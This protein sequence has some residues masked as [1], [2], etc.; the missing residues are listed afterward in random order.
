MSIRLA[1]I[2]VFTILIFIFLLS[3]FPA[4]SAAAN[5]VRAPYLQLVTSDSV[6]IVWRTDASDPLDDPTD[7][8]VQFGIVQ[9]NLVQ[10]IT[11]SSVKPQS[12]QNVRDHFVTLTGLDPNTLYYYD[13]GTISGGI[14]GGGTAEHYA[15]TAPVS[16][17]KTAFR[18]WVVG[19]TGVG[20]GNQL[21]VRDAMLNETNANG[22]KQDLFL[23]LGDIAYNDGTDSEFT[24]KHF[25]VYQDIL[26]NTPFYSAY[27]N[28]EA[29]SSNAA[30]QTGPYYEA[31]VLPGNGQAGGVASNTEAYYSFDYANV[32]FVV[33]DSSESSTE[34]GS[35]QISW[36]T[37][38]LAT[39]NQ[40][41]IIAMA[42]HS[43]YTKGT[44][45]SDNG[46]DSD[47]LQVKMRE[48]VLQVLEAGG[49]DLV[50]SGHS[51]AYERSFLIDGVY[52]FGS[53]PNFVT[54]NFVTLQNNG[55]I[56]DS[57]N[58]NP[59]G[60]GEYTKNSDKEG[61]V[62]LVSGTGGQANG[63]FFGC[64]H[65]VM[66]IGE[67][68]LSS[69]LLDVDGYTI[70][71]RNVRSS[72]IISDTFVM[73]KPERAPVI[74]DIKVLNP[75]TIE[76]LFNEVLDS[77]SAEILTNYTID[78]GIGVNGVTL[79]ADQK[80][81]TLTTDTLSFDFQYTVTATGVL[82]LTPSSNAS[83]DSEQFF[84]GQ[85]IFCSYLILGL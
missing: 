55:H 26:R 7:S 2:K 67:P 17:S 11:G 75:N 3:G 46:N 39:T 9:N 82:D 28:H 72:G 57:G 1:E 64:N 6:T 50:M 48:N 81:V 8:Q 38:D 40:D 41:W 51:H 63:C 84:F 77:V 29:D 65:P 31:F 23:H 10:S 79:E 30:L 21:A 19:D 58:G 36:L 32:H 27:G 37:N 33:I 49:V 13:V 68:D 71:V 74:S 69:I 43:P 56:I 85:C 24:A 35:P 61:T 47:G 62:Y 76:V 14:Q 4:I 18:A 44:H 54:P 60:E 5:L 80:T 25:S 53:A 70:T 42:H 16:G 12:N 83:N 66:S 15:V 73:A 34:P 52:G 59:S 20:N 78:S 22:L 45:D